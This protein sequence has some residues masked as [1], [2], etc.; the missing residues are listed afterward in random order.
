MLKVIDGK[1]YVNNIETNDTE[2]I[3]NAFKD[4]AEALHDK[5]NLDCNFDLSEGKN[6][7]EFRAISSNYEFSK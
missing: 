4:F 5:K 7:I 3:G 6:N 1:I 2:L